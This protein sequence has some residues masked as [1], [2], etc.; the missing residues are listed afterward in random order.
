MVKLLTETN[1]QV[2]EWL[3]KIADDYIP[4]KNAQEEKY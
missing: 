2:R 4:E 1:Q 3:R